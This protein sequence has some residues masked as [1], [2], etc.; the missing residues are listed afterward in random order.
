MNPTGEFTANEPTGIDLARIALWFTYARELGA[1]AGLGMTR[2]SIWYN[3]DYRRAIRWSFATVCPT[4]VTPGTR[5][6]TPRPASPVQVLFRN[7]F[8]Y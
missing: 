5:S 8:I 3:T 2:Q 7:P 4:A 1:L 6:A